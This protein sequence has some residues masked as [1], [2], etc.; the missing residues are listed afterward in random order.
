MAES[1]NLDRQS[2]MQ[3]FNFAFIKQSGDFVADFNHA[4]LFLI[5]DVSDVFKAPEN[6]IRRAA[7]NN[8]KRRQIIDGQTAVNCFFR[9]FLIIDVGRD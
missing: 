5:N 8:F 2:L 3:F 1:K 7:E 6:K 9:L 4:G